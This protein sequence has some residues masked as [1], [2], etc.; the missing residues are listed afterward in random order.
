MFILAVALIGVVIVSFSGSGIR[1][2]GETLGVPAPGSAETLQAELTELAEEETRIAGQMENDREDLAAT[3]AAAGT[4]VARV[5]SIN[6][7]LAVTMRAFIPPTQQMIENAGPVTPGMNEPL[8]GQENAAALAPVGTPGAGEVTAG[9]TGGSG[10]SQFTEIGTAQAVRES[11]GCA[12]D[13]T[14]QF[15]TSA[16]RVYATTRALNIT[17]GTAVYAEWLS[18]GTRVSQSSVYTVEQNDDDFCLWFYLEP[19]DAPFTAGNWSV[20]FYAD[21]ASV[22]GASFTFG[23]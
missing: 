17:A 8:P 19:S 6:E 16:T 13:R 22:G 2:L 15:S 7:Q 21:G 9:Q 18:N 4:Y 10:Q 23:A 20:Q 11:D 1:G 12:A 3:A 14:A 5:D